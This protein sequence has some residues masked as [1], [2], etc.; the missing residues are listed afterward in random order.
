M[1]P[2]KTRHGVLLVTNEF[3]Y[4]YVTT[5]VYGQDQWINFFC[6]EFRRTRVKME[7]FGSS[8]KRV[9]KIVGVSQI[10]T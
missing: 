3:D 6:Q 10:Q 4:V 1:K 5:R 9:P 7:L 8:E 2:K